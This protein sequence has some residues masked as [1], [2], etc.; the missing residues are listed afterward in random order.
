[1][2]E[3]TET[4]DVPTLA[5]WAGGPEAVG[6]LTK[7]FYE[8]VPQDPVL[9]PVFAQ[10]IRIMPNTSQPSSPKCLAVRRAYTRGGGSHAHMIIR[11]LGRHLTEAFR[12][13]WLALMLDTADEVGLPSDPEF[14]CGVLSDIWS[15]VPGLPC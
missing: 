5:E 3:P 15:G 8:K 2:T 4:A 14:R 11:H 7:R 13:R 6:A 1:M 12:R 9:A 10:W